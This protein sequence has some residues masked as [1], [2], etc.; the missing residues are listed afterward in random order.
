MT[1]KLSVNVNK[2]ACLRNARGGNTPN[3]A[4]VTQRIIDAGADGITVH[5]RPDLRHITPGDV[6]ELRALCKDCEFNIEGNPFHETTSNYPGIVTMARETLPD[7]VTL[8]PDS[9]QQITSNQGWDFKHYHTLLLPIINELKELN[10]RVSLFVNPD[11]E[12]ITHAA[13]T[14]CDRVELYTEHYAEEYLAGRGEASATHYQAMA[15][16][17]KDLNL[18]CNAGHDLNA[19]NLALLTQHLD[20]AEVS[21]GQALIADCLIDGVD[22]SI[23]RY[24]KALS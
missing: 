8:V 22:A 24:K 18:A 14:G 1:T 9:I 2:V 5:P 20:F 17:A 23:K 4:Y 10:I 16:H 3:V 7:Q 6:F 11:K 15:Q 12:S 13:N 21:I 19:D